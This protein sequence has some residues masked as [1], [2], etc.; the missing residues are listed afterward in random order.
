MSSVFGVDL[1]SE[2]CTLST[3]DGTI[4]RNELGGEGIATLVSFNGKQRHIGEAA[5]SQANSNASNT[6]LH[7]NRL[8]GMTHD[9]YEQH[10]LKDH[11]R[12]SCEKAADSDALVFAADYND[13]RL[14]FSSER[15]LSMLLVNIKNVA[16]SH[17]ADPSTKSCV[18]AVPGSFTAS[19]NQAVVDAGK[20]AGMDVRVCSYSDALHACYQQERKVAEGD[21]ARTVMF[22]DIGLTTTSCSIAHFE[23]GCDAAPRAAEC[24]SNLGTRNFMHRVWVHFASEVKEKL[25]VDVKPGTKSGQ[26][27]L[28]G[29]EKVVK[30]LSQ[31]ADCSVQVEQIAPDQD[32]TLKLNRTQLDALVAT[33][34]DSLSALVARTL[35]ASGAPTGSAEAAGLEVQ[36]VGGGTRIPWV[37]ELL[38]AATGAKGGCSK[39]LDTASAVAKGAAYIASPAIAAAN[40]AAKAAKAA[41]A[42]EAVQA[43]EAAEAAAKAEGGEGGAEADAA[44]DQPEPAAEAAPAPAPAP[45]PA[46][47]AV[48]MGM[49]ADAVASAVAAEAEMQAR[50]AEL[51]ATSEQRN[52]LE[53]F[54]FQWRDAGST[55]HGAMLDMGAINKELDAVEDWLY[56]EEADA[57]DLATLRGKFDGASAAVT[58]LAGEYCAKV[59]EDKAVM[60]KEMEVEAAAAA[61]ERAASGESDDHDFRKLK[62][63]DRMKLVGAN[64]DEGTELFKGKN[65]KPAAARYNKA[66]TH[67]AKFFD[68]SPDQQSEVDKVKVSLNLNMAMCYIKMENWLKVVMHC[69]DTLALPEQGGNPKALY[70]RGMAHEAT[71]KYEEAQA[72]LKQALKA[73]PEDKAI[74]KLLERVKEQIKRQLAKEKK[75][76]GKMF[77]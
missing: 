56:S 23:A 31:L 49:A 42:A 21:A 52:G 66:L 64:K 63:A 8:V 38:T 67:A 53:A 55:K 62:F 60:E 35:E 10:E 16:S 61:A 13:E 34:R 58:G 25:K 7:I 54:V 59:A 17:F 39:L 9:A 48:G 18:I 3:E 68:L 32:F 71:K 1:G 12:F 24:N 33:E 37:Q 43:A 5:V 28:V 74:A 14:Q 70:R 6:I 20:I 69:D 44:V 29:C 50:D 4:I 45:A 2:S 22:V 27:L 36:I 46:Q 65:W 47:A 72:D 41:E 77:S 30:L 19:Q 57:A 73:S 51:V 75:M 15:V 11:Y 26:R 76:Y 40:A